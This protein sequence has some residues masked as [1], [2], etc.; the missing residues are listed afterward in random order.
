MQAHHYEPR[1][2]PRFNRSS[3]LA[4]IIR[5]PIEKSSRGSGSLGPTKATIW[6]KASEQT[7]G[8]LAAMGKLSPKEVQHALN[9]GHLTPRAF[10]KVFWASIDIRHPTQEQ[11]NM[12]NCFA[13]VLI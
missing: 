11:M 8:E 3:P 6:K 9:K 2:K 12:I 7:M 1:M 13:D 4:N 10:K 5:G